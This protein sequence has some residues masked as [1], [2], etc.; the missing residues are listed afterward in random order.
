[1]FPARAF[2]VCQVTIPKFNPQTFCDAVQRERVT[3]TVLVPTMI[4]M[5][6][7]F[8]DLK[9]YDL[10]SLKHLGYGGS[11]IATGLGHCSTQ[12]LLNV[13]PVQVYGLSAAG[14]LTGVLG[15][16]DT[17]GKLTP[18]RRPLPRIEV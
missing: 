10:T 2:G 5:L 14:F 1:M 8:P 17:E 11:P 9:K 6:T 3:H 4:N 13:K 18:C 7:Q 16:A 15:R 12:A